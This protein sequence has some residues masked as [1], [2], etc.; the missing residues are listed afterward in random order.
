MN[1]V[2]K[3]NQDTLTE[4]E[5]QTGEIEKFPLSNQQIRQAQRDDPDVRTMINL[6]GAGVKPNKEERRRHSWEIQQMLQDFEMFYI[7]QGV[8]YKEQL[9][10]EPRLGDQARLVLPRQLKATALFGHMPIQSPDI[11]G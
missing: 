7:H 11:W 5:E 3:L 9:E 4:L 2:E 6:V 10:N 8:L 1:A